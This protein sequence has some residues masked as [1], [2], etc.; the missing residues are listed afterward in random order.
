MPQ[1]ILN[2]KTKAMSIFVPNVPPPI[3]SPQLSSSNPEPPAPPSPRALL[4]DPIVGYVS[5]L[6]PIS[7][8]NS[9]ALPSSPSLPPS[10]QPQPS[11]PSPR[12]QTT[13]IPIP[14]SL[15]TPPLRSSSSPPPHRGT[16]QQRASTALQRSPN[17]SVELLLASSPASPPQASASPA[18]VSSPLMQQSPYGSPQASPPAALAHLSS[19]HRVKLVHGGPHNAPTPVFFQSRS[20]A[21]QVPRKSSSADTLVE[22]PPPQLLRTSTEEYLYLFVCGFV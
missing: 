5:P 6:S 15:Y 13:D 7:L 16:A 9:P 14:P 22:S 11:P 2:K 12:E 20:H 17:S 1:E 21:V 18:Q 3:D 8:P 19:Q 10:P 4:L